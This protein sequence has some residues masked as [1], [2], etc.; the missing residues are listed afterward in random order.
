M[1]GFIIDITTIDK[2][3][4]SL[5]YAIK[6]SNA[7]YYR[8]N[9]KGYYDDVNDAWLKLYGYNRDEVIGKHY[10]LSRTEDDLQKLDEIISQ[11]KKGKSYSNTIATRKCKD[12]STGKHVLSANPVYRNEEVDGMEGFILNLD[13]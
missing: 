10:S 3:S 9:S 8:I 6:N 4:D 11:V 12:G 5:H 13:S 1:E 7:G 2:D